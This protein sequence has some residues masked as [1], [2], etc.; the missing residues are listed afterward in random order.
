MMRKNIILKPCF[1]LEFYKFSMYIE[2]H[3]WNNIVKQLIIRQLYENK[4]IF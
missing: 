3:I 2:M 4:K 1:L